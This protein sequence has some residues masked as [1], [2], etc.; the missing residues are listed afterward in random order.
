[1]KQAPIP[2]N[3]AQR[4]KTLYAMGVL[5]TENEERFDR[6]TRIATHLFDV[7]ISTVTLVDS[8]RE[9]FKS[10][11]G[12]EQKEGERAISFCG[13]AMLAESIL[14]IPD[15]TKDERF[16]DNPMVVGKPFIRFYAGVPL[17]AADHTRIGTFCIKAHEPK[18]LT[19]EQED[20]LRSLAAWTER[21]L[22][23]HELSTAL[24]T[25][26]KAELALKEKV[27]E[28]ERMNKLMVD[29]EL[30]MAELKEQLKQCEPYL[31]KQS[32]T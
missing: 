6:I 31:K 23:V 11:Q 10:C 29:R 3:E 26:Q 32:G 2:Q 14:V 22:N 5:N 30:K 20:D 7:P 13:H 28:L 25:Q 18:E 4:I 27:D 24:E 8:N 15:A 19:K 1:M 16:A 21:E 9:W 17:H 12:L